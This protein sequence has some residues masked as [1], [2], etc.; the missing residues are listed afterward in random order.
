MTKIEDPFKPALR[1]GL[2]VIVVSPGTRG[3]ALKIN[4]LRSRK[5]LKPLRIVQIP[6]VLAEDRKPIS[7]L[8]IRKGETDREGCLLT[9]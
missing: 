2:D 5:G 6:W 4:L 3:N 8:S 1:E 7:D 9:S